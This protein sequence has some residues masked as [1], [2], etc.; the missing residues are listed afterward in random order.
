MRY[1]RP[2]VKSSISNFHL[3]AESQ[4]I[5]GLVPDGNGCPTVL[6]SG[7][8]GTGIVNI[9]GSFT[10]T[11]KFDNGQ[12]CETQTTSF[13]GQAAFQNG[14]LLFDCSGLQTDCSFFKCGVVD[15]NRIS[16]EVCLDSLNINGEAQ[17]AGVCVELSI[18][19][20]NTFANEVC[21]E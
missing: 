12:S 6:F 1:S 2:E 14:A 3:V 17:N 9:D 21:P 4:Y 16:G 7:D 19:D 5:V 10:F 11:L 18:Q 13:T 8:T 20:F 15:A